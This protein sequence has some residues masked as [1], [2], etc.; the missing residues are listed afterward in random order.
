MAKIVLIDDDDSVRDVLKK[1]LE[2]QGHAVSVA[3]DGPTGLTL[4]RDESPDLVVTDI[5]MTGKDG[6]DV[7]IELKGLV[8]PSRIVA[9]SGDRN[10]LLDVAQALGAARTLRKPF[11][12]DDFLA[13]IKDV[14]R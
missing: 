13:T 1:A 8:T 3:S 14:L 7:I 9:I 5:G 12:L 11:L 10:D 2:K 6:I 4:C